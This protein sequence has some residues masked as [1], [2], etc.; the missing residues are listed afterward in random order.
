[1]MKQ[2][3]VVLKD[4][5]RVSKAVLNWIKVNSSGRK[6]GKGVHDNK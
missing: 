5:M 4:N 2:N 1:M 6:L 3:M